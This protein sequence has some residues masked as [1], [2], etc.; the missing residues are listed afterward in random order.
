MKEREKDGGK[1]MNRIE[2]ISFVWKLCWRLYFPRSRN[3]TINWCNSTTFTEKSM[4]TNY[5]QSTPFTGSVHINQRS[6]YVVM[7]TFSDLARSRV[8]CIASVTVSTTLLK[9]VFYC[10]LS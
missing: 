10:I 2:T 9:D 6:S 8:R 7:F 5:Q 3:N 1:Q 4:S